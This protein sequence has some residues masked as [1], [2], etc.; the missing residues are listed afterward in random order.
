MTLRRAIILAG[1]SGAAAIAGAAMLL[2]PAPGPRFSEAREV[3]W[4]DLLPAEDLERVPRLAD[5]S[6]AR[7]L[8]EH[9][10]L[11][12]GGPAPSEL[13]SLLG[14]SGNLA[15]APRRVSDSFGG[16]G[17]LRALQPRGGAARGDLDGQVIRMAGFVTPL[18]FDGPNLVEFLL[19]PYVGACV[20]VP[21][22]PANQI[23]VVT[24]FRDRR[25]DKGLL[26][27]VRV[28]GVLRAA[29]SDTV[30]ARA[31]YRIDGADVEPFQ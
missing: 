18:A 23:V 31:E 11:G 28:A 4:L 25:R 10:Q 12:Y 20:H 13:A 9:G 16:L 17:N 19:V 6:L 21:P 8:I 22:P 1:L 29:A 5:G 2:R 27:P 30:Y 14:A 15:D 3:D 26:H 24:D 7:G